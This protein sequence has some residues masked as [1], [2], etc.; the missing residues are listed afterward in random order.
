LLAVISLFVSTIAV[1]ISVLAL[2]QA[3]K[4]GSLEKRSEAIIQVR[5]A[6][7]DVMMHARVD[8]KTSAGIREAYQTSLLVFSKKVSDKLSNLA[9]MAFQLEHKSFDQMTDKDWGD[10]HLLGDE[11]QKVLVEMQS[12]TALSKWL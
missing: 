5:T 4:T 6:L 9:E 3:R 8:S 7:G 12:E 10:Q 2:I 11:L 1:T